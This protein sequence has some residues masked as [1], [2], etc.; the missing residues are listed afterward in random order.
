[1]ASTRVSAALLT[2]GQSARADRPPLARSAWI[3]LRNYPFLNN[4]VEYRRDTVV[5]RDVMTKVKN[6]V[7]LSDEGWTF[8]RLGELA[9]AFSPLT[10]LTRPLPQRR[11]WRLRRS[12]AGSRS[13]AVSPTESSSATLRGWSFRLPSVSHVLH[14]VESNPLTPLPYL[15]PDPRQR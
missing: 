14:P 1:M 10:S 4:K 12:I 2:R 8:D 7:Y 5:A 13:C 9:S 6:V 15:R 3:N 11:F